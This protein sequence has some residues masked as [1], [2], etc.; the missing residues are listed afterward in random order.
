MPRM[1]INP[2]TIMS[3]KPREDEVSRRMLSR[4]PNSRE[5]I[6]NN[7]ESCPLFFELII[8]RV[9]GDHEKNDFWVVQ[10]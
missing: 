3:Q 7:S 5:G 2:E 10:A 1:V 6:I 9:T 8:K 4:E